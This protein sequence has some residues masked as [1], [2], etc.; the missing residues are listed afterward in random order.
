MPD[1]ILFITGV[2]I[3]FLLC[4]LFTEL[5]EVDIFRI[6][7]TPFKIKEFFD[8]FSLPESVLISDIKA[9]LDREG[10]QMKEE[11]IKQGVR[12]LILQGEIPE[13]FEVVDKDT[14]Y[15]IGILK[16][17]NA[18]HVDGD[19]HCAVSILIFD[20]NGN[21]L[22]QRRAPSVA[23][24]NRVEVSAS[25]HMAPGETSQE[26]ALREAEEEVG[27]KINPED[28][29]IIGA[30]YQFVKIGRIDVEQDHFEGDTYI[31]YSDNPSNNW[32]RL[33]LFMYIAT[34][35]EV[36][37][38]ERFIEEKKSQEVTSVRFANLEEELKKFNVSSKTYSSIFNMYLSQEWILDK[39][40]EYLGA[41]R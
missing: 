7:R 38:I 25:G 2:Q 33:S 21:L 35:E 8:Y 19:W 9:F 31:H 40:N 4:A 1:K 16:Q 13:Y 5:D 29:I 34:D 37:M 18:V 15:P 22:L 10:Y 27:L 41:Q 28:I 36:L 26:S 3:C 11:E 39:I 12:E 32:E 6:V 23:E 24:P 14:G 30:P 20:K 17:R